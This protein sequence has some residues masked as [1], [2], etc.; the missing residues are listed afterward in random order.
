[1]VALTGVAGEVQPIRRVREG[2]LVPTR[3]TY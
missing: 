1:V 3:W 2:R